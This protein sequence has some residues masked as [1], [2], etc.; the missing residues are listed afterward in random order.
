MKGE[1]V[2]LCDEKEEFG[3]EFDIIQTKGHLIQ[4][5]E[6][7]NQY[8]PVK[9]TGYISHA[10]EAEVIFVCVSALRQEK[11]ANWM[12]PYVKIKHCIFIMPGNLGALCFY[13][14]FKDE[15]IEYNILA[16]ISEC[17]WAC[18]KIGLGKV[19]SALPLSEKKV[20]S[21][22]NE[23]TK[24][25]VTLLKQWFPVVQGNHVIENMLNSPNVLTHLSGTILN[26]G[27]IER[28]K[29]NYALFLDGLNNIYLD[30]LEILENERKKVLDAYDMMSYGVPMRA[31]FEKIEEENQTD[32]WRCFKTLSGPDGINHRYVTE[33]AMCGVALLVSM[34]KKRQIC[35]P[36]TEALLILA[37]SKNDYV[38]TGRTV[39]W[40]GEYWNLLI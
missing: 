14:L 9:V 31:F 38:M 35:I 28:R 21:V 15:G 13:R 11:I 19:V 20:N 3:E 26:I 7:Y 16:E 34:G 24:E 17:F 27:E 12:K 33:D 4:G 29:H 1:D 25:A 32:L 39:E 5:P 2:I 18:R 30:C 23:K 40:I 6:F 37:F 10:M 8:V 36:V 22:P